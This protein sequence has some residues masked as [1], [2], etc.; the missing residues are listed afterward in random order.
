MSFSRTLSQADF[1]KLK[2]NYVHFITDDNV[3]AVIEDIISFALPRME[4]TLEE[5]K[6]LYE[7]IEENIELST[8]GLFPNLRSGRISLRPKRN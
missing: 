1:I 2:L 8:I 3:M 7:F 5:G 6:E 4:K